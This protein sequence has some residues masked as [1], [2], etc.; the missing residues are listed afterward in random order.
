MGFAIPEGPI[1]STDFHQIDEQVLRA[2]TRGFGQYFRH[3]FIKQA[4]LLRSA[5]GAQCDLHEHYGI[6]A[7]NAIPNGFAIFTRSALTK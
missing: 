2:Q 6:R 3:A 4:L 7:M 1:F 5:A